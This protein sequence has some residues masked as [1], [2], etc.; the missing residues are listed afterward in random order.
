MGFGIDPKSVMNRNSVDI[1]GKL[2]KKKQRE[3]MDVWVG[4]A[5]WGRGGDEEMTRRG[6]TRRAAV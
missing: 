4:G 1:G 3:W 6:L 5:W 2:N